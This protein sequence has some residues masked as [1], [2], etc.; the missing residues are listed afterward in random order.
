[1]KIVRSKREGRKV[2]KKEK[3]SHQIDPKESR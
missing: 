3:E 1:M 2:V